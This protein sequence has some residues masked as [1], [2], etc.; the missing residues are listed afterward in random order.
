M[1]Q[2]RFL[3]IPIS[4]L[5]ASMLLVN[6]C[7]NRAFHTVFPNPFSYSTTI[8]FDMYEPG[9]AQVTVVDFRG[10][11]V[12]RLFSGDL[13]AGAHQFRLDARNMAPGRY[14]VL[15]RAGN[16]FQHMPMILVR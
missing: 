13:D 10:A 15:I 5:C 8:S 6:G 9:S 16:S 4:F 2:A 1:K 7:L 3:R 11:E 12:A 14:E